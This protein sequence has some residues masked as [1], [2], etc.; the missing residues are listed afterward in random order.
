VL[1]PLFGHAV[2]ALFPFDQANGRADL[3]LNWGTGS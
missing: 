1:L 2:A 3:R